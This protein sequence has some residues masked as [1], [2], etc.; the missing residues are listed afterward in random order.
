MG[1]GR[2][3]LGAIIGHLLVGLAA[4][5]PAHLACA[6]DQPRD[7]SPENPR[8]F[9]HKPKSPY[10]DLI[11]AHARANHVPESLVHRVI[12]RESQYNPRLVGRGGTMGLMQIKH[13]TAR[14]L[15]Y[16]G[17]PAGLLDPAT[18]L[19]YAVRYLA[20]A[21]QAAGGDADRAIRLFAS[22]Y[23][24]PTSRAHT[25]AASPAVGAPPEVTAP[26]TLG[27]AEMAA[28]TLAVAAA[29]PAKVAPTTGK[30]NAASKR[31]TG[32]RKT[33][34]MREAAPTAEEESNARVEPDPTPGGRDVG[35]D[36]TPL[37]TLRRTFRSLPQAG[38]GDR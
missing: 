7:P 9:Q 35:T 32:K 6:Q 12:V 29:A 5:A 23:Y 30:R 14:S 26:P 34:V 24:V 28:P 18:N 38:T 1:R 37:Q 36:T 13:A 10:D 11:A 31:A 21:F 2:T 27:P 8:S 3:G 33:S 20:G 25:I 17:S 22:G 15:G 4:V 19:T 16:T